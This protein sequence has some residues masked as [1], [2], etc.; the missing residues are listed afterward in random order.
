MLLCGAATLAAAAM[1]RAPWRSPNDLPG[2]ALDLQALGDG[3]EVHAGSIVPARQTAP[4]EPFSIAPDAQ[5]RVAVAGPDLDLSADRCPTATLSFAADKS[6]HNI[7]CTFAWRRAGDPNDYRIR[8]LR[9]DDPFAAIPRVRFAALDLPLHPAWK[10]R[11]RRIDWT[12]DGVGAPLQGISLDLPAARGGETA[13]MLWRQWWHR[14]PIGPATINTIRAPHVLG[15]S[16]NALLALLIVLAAGAYGLIASARRWDIRPTVLL[17]LLLAAWLLNDARWAWAQTRQYA[18]DRDRFGGADS[19]DLEA[20]LWP[21]AIAHMAELARQHLPP[22]AVYAVIGG[23][24][25][26]ASESS[27]TVRHYGD[28]R[29][30]YLLSPRWVQVNLDPL[31]PRVPPRQAKYLLVLDRRLVEIDATTGTVRAPGWLPAVHVADDPAAGIL[32][33]R[34]VGA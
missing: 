29:L 4:T 9:V 24:L 7:S 20:R 27:Q 19:A 11:I 21:P 6:S 14:E 18:A 10:G 32:I 16:P 22:G 3:W 5:G 17:T 34:M 12:L 26:T 23:N 15:Y 31:Q 30:R 2:V 28:S 25:V 33:A 1:L 13:A 8:C